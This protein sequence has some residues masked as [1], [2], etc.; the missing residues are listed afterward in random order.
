M[1]R[2]SRADF[3]ARFPRPNP[4]EHFTQARNVL[5]VDRDMS[6]DGVVQDLIVRAGAKVLIT[7]LV[8]RSLTVDR[9]AI[10]YVD[11]L[12]D[13]RATVDGALCVDGGHV[14]RSLSGSGIV[15]DPTEP[16][17]SEIG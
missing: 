14:G 12:I 2:L 10:V 15:F 13:G 11:G 3:H 5:I 9:D 8:E 16:A 6:V 1:L 7:G 4:G 17:D